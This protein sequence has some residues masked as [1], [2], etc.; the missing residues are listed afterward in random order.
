MWQNAAL[1]AYA[2][3]ESS[4]FPKLEKFTTKQEREKTSAPDWRT[5]L[6]AVRGW[7]QGNKKG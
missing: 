1:T 6:A 2:P 4:K 5:Q 7:V 3:G